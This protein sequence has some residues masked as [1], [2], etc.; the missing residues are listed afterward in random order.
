LPIVPSEYLLL[1]L[2]DKHSRTDGEAKFS[3]AISSNEYFDLLDSWRSKLQR[4]GSVDD[5]C[6]KCG[7]I[8]I[9]DVE[10]ADGAEVEDVD[11]DVNAEEWRS[12]GLLFLIVLAL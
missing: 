8:C 2:E 11:A 6:F 12:D 5:K 4:V 3:D 1:T 7:G 9:D 10:E